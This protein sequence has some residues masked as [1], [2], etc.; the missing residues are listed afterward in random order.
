[1]AGKSLIALA[2]CFAAACGSLAEE[3]VEVYFG[4]GCF[5]HVQHEFIHAEETILGRSSD[6]YTSLSGY[7]GGTG[8]AAPQACYGNYE[9]LGHTEVVRV[10]IPVS[11]LSAF[12]DVFWG[13][14][15]NYDRVDTMDIG[16][17]YRAAIGI[18]GGMNSPHFQHLRPADTTWELR[19]GEGNDADTLG[20]PLVWV[21][22]IASYPFHQAEV[23]HQFHDD[24]MA[25]GQYPQS[26]NDYQGVLL[27][28]CRMRPTGCNRDQGA[29][30]A[31]CSATAAAM[32]S[33]VAAPVPSWHPGQTTGD[34]EV[35]G[36]GMGMGSD[37]EDAQD[38]T[39]SAQMQTPLFVLALFS[40][41]A[42]WN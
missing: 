31:T 17:D 21:Y 15:V 25:G 35:G 11:K 40:L 5:W 38:P 41:V 26:Y 42:T 4:S 34:I 23:Y 20:S 37:S 24:F 7:A 2:V 13:L 39:S 36:S 30:P 8:V 19:T 32:E 28:D 3:C 27:G 1:M 6:S 9:Q 22:D 16:A 33:C 10:L 12:A 29:V 14:F 18:A